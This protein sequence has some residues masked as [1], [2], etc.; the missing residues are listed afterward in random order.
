MNIF[1]HPGTLKRWALDMSDACGSV[2]TNKA[3]DIKKIDNLV[4]QF[5][6]D[7]N[8]NMEVVANA[9]KEE[10]SQKTY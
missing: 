8:E 6:K 4:E 9:S 2:I 5:V 3:P 10:A 7:Y 1:K